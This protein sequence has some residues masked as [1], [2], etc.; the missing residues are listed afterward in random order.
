MRADLPTEQVANDNPFGVT[1]YYDDVQKL[2]SRKHFHA[3]GSDLMG[4]SL[5]GAQQQRLAGLASSVK[6]SRYLRPTKRTIGQHPA[7]FPGKRDSLGHAL[8]NDIHADFGQSID[9]RFSGT[10]IATFDRVV[11]Q[12]INPIT[13]VLIIL[14]GV[15]T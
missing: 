7:V 14:S 4:E 13:V 6:S 11:K 12:A 2:G 1:V 5:V 9:I 8:V 15:N 10:E 3:A